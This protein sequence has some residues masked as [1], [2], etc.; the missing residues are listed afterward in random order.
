MITEFFK[1]II[2]N[3]SFWDLS[4]LGNTLG[5]YVVFLLL[6]FFL[7]VIL[8]LF[9]KLILNNIK[10]RINGNARKIIETIKPPFFWYVAFFLSSNTLI[11][12]QFIENIIRAIL[13]IWI[14]YQIGLIIQ[15]LVDNLLEKL[16]SKESDQGTKTAIRTIGKIAKALIWLF[17]GLFVLSNLGINVTSVMAGIGIGGIAVAFALQNIL[18]DLFSSFAIFFDK[19]FVVGDFIV[20]GGQAGVVEKIGI[21]TTRMRALQGEEI[22]ISNKELTSERIQNFKKLTKRRVVFNFGVIY[23]T[24]NK[25]LI[26]ITEIIKNIIKEEE[27][28]ELDRVHF[29]KFGDSALEFE[30]V[31]YVLSPEYNDYMDTHQRILLKIKEAFES[32]KIEMAFP[33]QT[34]FIQK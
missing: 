4:I 14:T 23:D 15:I 11:L 19:P 30:V 7:F 16:S 29:I 20:V 9:R 8:R 3:Y 18:T 21:K 10:K 5:D 24:P 33:T 27:I 22:V 17:A 28:A 34:L 26:K 12:P 1:K 25:K 2:G 31:Y 32:E 13:V 6:F